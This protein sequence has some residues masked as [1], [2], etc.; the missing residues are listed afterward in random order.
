MINFVISNACTAVDKVSCWV[1]ES[2]TFS[3]EGDS[4]SA[5][6]SLKQCLIALKIEVDPDPTFHKCD[7]EFM[8]LCAVVQA[9]ESKE[10][11]WH[12]MAED[13]ASIN[14]IGAVLLVS[15]VSKLDLLTFA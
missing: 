6:Q 12:P 5:F 9:L 3:Q 13:E 8:R 2:R 15:H 4:A 10:I 14:A 7:L 11:V 1:L